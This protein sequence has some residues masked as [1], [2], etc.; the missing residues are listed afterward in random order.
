MNH[1][2]RLTP[3]DLQS[4]FQYAHTLCQ[5]RDDAY[6]LVQSSVERYLKECQSGAKVR[7]PLAYIRTLIRNRFIDQFRH[8]QRWP[9][10]PYEETSDYDISPLDIESLHINQQALAQVWKTLSPQDRD[11]LYHWAILGYSTDEACAHLGMARGSFLSRIHR[12]RKQCKTLDHAHPDATASNEQQT[13]M[14]SNRQH[15]EDNQS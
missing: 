7:K 6:D 4:L 3:E 10:Q 14:T 11:I 9:S 2:V 8:H 1:S 13:P 5:H 15:Q 12:L